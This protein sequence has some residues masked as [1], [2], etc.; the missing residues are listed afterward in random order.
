[1]YSCRDPQRVYKLTLHRKQ[2]KNQWFRDDPTFTLVLLAFLVVSA[3]A[4]GLAYRQTSVW[5]YLWLIQ[6]AIASFAL[7]GAILSVTLWASINRY[8]RSAV[9]LPHSVEQKVEWLYAWDVHCNAF[10]PV[11]LLT[12]VLQYFLLPL[13]MGD[14]FLPALLGNTIYAAALCHYFYITFWG[15]SGAYK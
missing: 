10:V 6:G 13:T 15:Y 14:G 5:A 4:Y 11:L 7:W 3:V 9:P 8:A 12:H 2:T 1:V